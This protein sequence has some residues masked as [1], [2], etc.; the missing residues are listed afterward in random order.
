MSLKPKKRSHQ[1][2]TSSWLSLFANCQLR[3][4]AC[5]REDRN[6]FKCAAA[7]FIAPT[8]AQTPGTANKKGEEMHLMRE[9][10]RLIG[11]SVGFSAGDLITALRGAA[12]GD[13]SCDV[14]HSIRDDPLRRR[15][16]LETI[17][18]E[19][20]YRRCS[21]QQQHADDTLAQSAPVHLTL[22]LLLLIQRAAE[23]LLL[24]EK[25]IASLQLWACLRRA[26]AESLSG[27][28]KV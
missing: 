25:Y 11:P 27:I 5:E 24:E 28:S 8:C 4:P 13:I 18:P 12:R 22:L 14:L 20:N 21:Q 23:M 3:Y 2:E 16:I 7:A 6:L 15:L 1:R 19:S 10:L 26:R 9:P 17:T